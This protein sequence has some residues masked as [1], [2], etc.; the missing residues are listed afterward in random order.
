MTPLDERPYAPDLAVILAL[1]LLVLVV[2]SVVG[3]AL[4]WRTRGRES[5]V[6]DNVN[7]RIRAWWLMAATL[8]VAFL[9]GET[10]IVIL[11]AFVSFNAL[12][13]FLTLTRRNRA[14]HYALAASFFL[15]LPLQYLAIGRGWIGF[16]SVLIPVYAFLGLPVLAILRHRPG[17]FLSRISETQWALMVTVYCLSHVP[18]LLALGIPGFAGREVLLIVFLIVVV[19]SG[20]VL[21]Q[22]TSLLVGRRLIAPEIS[23]FRT[24]EGAVI[25]VA[26]ASAIG[27]ALWWIT[28]FTPG[29]AI[30]MALVATLTGTAGSLVMSAIKRDRGV[31]EWGHLL[32]AHGGVLDR[33][34]SV[35]FAA[36]VFF[37]LCRALW[38]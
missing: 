7:A 17:H 12:R 31:R 15:V 5:V 29:A 36:P 9:L 18:A 33:L 6:I 32:E 28:P 24:W 38:A 16:A 20:D 23:R 8:S 37:H 27:G 11:F 2:A 4:A 35:A 21:Q 34:D 19:Q 22:I 13:E 30:L 3:G 14:D 25:G 26:G 1:L 10:A